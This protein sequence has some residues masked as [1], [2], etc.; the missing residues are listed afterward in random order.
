M[1]SF[2]FKLVNCEDLINSQKGEIT[3]K[4]GDH[5]VIKWFHPRR[6]ENGTITISEN[7]DYVFNLNDFEFLIKNIKNNTNHKYYRDNEVIFEYVDNMFKVDP[8]TMGTGYNFDPDE[9]NFY[10]D[11]NDNQIKNN[12]LAV[13]TEIYEWLKSIC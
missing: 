7:G 6:K 5:H 1:T 13:L 11:L 9:I 10:I 8:H 3:I 2:E 12:L 4:N